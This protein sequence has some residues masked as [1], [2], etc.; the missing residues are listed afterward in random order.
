MIEDEGAQRGAIETEGGFDFEG[1]PEGE[2]EG[3]EG[4]GDGGEGEREGAGGGG[5]P[6]ESGGPGVEP[7][8]TAREP[9]GEEDGELGGGLGEVELGA[10]AVVVLAAQE[11]IGIVEG[12]H[13]LGERFGE[14][15]EVQEG[16]DQVQVIEDDHAAEGCQ[17][18]GV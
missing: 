16:D 4:G 1:L 13:G 9:K 15:G 14:L 11:G 6:A 3:D 5:I 12:A 17:E 10:L 18:P 7:T 8:E 2:G